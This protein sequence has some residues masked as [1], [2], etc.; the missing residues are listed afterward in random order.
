M[1]FSIHFDVNSKEFNQLVKTG[2]LN[3]VGHLALPQPQDLL[4]P[5]M[6]PHTS[7]FYFPEHPI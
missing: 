3:H 2:Y 6:Q 5:P 1:S 4:A 7:I